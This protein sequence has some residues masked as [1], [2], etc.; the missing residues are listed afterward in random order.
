MK[1]KSIKELKASLKWVSLVNDGFDEG[2][3]L[4]V[5]KAIKQT[6]VIIKRLEEIIE[7]FLDDDDVVQVTAEVNKLIAELKGDDE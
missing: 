2:R 5:R 4:E 3:R 1:L 7:G 6:E